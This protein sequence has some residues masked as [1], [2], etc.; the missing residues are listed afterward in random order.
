M[1]DVGRNWDYSCS[2]SELSSTITMLSSE[3][4]ELWLLGAIVVAELGI[5]VVGTDACMG[6]GFGGTCLGVCVGIAVE[7]VGV[8]IG[9]VAGV[10]KEQ[11]F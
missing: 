5:F 4:V 6:W 9:V 3:G 8:F 1:R 10:W 2:F 7:E 11:F